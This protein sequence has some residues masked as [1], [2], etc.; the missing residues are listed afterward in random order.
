MLGSG[1]GFAYT[2]GKG[3][4]AVPPS[5]EIENPNPQSGT[6]NWYTQD[7]Y[8]GGS[9][10]NCSDHTQ[11]GVKQVFR[12]LGSLPYRTSTAI[13]QSGAYY[14]LNNYNPGYFGDGSVNTSEFTIP[15]TPQLTI[16]DSLDNANIGWRY[17]GDGWDLYLQ[18]PNF[19]NPWNNYCNICN[20]A[21][22]TSSIMTNPTLR[23]LHLADVPAVSYTHLTLPTKA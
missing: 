7:G 8:G 17:Y 21:Q 23:Q 13:C 11:P 15:P 20:F 14:L 3:N 19:N 22:Y 4:L 12:F 1:T 18:D 6:N 2:D 5:N 10:S 16:A 9:Y